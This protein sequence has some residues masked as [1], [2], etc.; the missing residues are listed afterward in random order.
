[1]KKGFDWWEEVVA[2]CQEVIRIPS[3]SG[4][5]KELADFLEG[6]MKELDYDEVRRDEVG[7]VIGKVEGDEKLSTVGFSAHMD[8]VSPGDESKWEFPPYSG[9]RSGG[10][11]HGRGASDT[12]GAI[13]TQLY[14][15]RLLDEAKTEHGDVYVVFVVL[16]EVGGFGSEQLD[17]SDLDYLI[18]GEPTANELRIGHR[19]RIELELKVKGK[20]AH[21]SVPEKAENPHF[22]MAEFMSKFAALE[23]KSAG[24]KSS[25]APTL[26]STD[27][28]SPNVI[29]SECSLIIDWRTIPGETETEVKGRVKKILPPAGE[30]RVVESE[31]ETYT[32]STF[33]QKG[34]RQPYYIE[35]DHRA[36]EEAEKA[37][38][39]V[40]EREV[41]VSWWDFATDAGFFDDAGIPV[42]GFSPCEEGYAHTSEDRVS[43]AL[44]KEALK[45]YP[46]IAGRL[47]AIK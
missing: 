22:P 43:L 47:S 16:E 24:R 38:K 10:Y 2:D 31:I 35:S 18:L 32:G 37:V 14:L 36:V 7:N 39:K 28:E 15:P 46:E 13:A 41:D 45:C 19:G 33:R 17:K 6:R 25:A 5:E 11:I 30:L 1:M 8:H 29:P 27:Q 26:F 20:S 44:M 3:L 42:I 9:A 4:Q 12:K 23:M 40:L 34:V 21:A